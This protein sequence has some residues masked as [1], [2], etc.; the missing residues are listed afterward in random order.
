ML[1]P[2]WD[3]SLQHPKIGKNIMAWG[4]WDDYIASIMIFRKCPF[5]KQK[6]KFCMVNSHFG[7]INRP[8]EFPLFLLQGRYCVRWWS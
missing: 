8:L 5:V 7:I 1:N 2:S 4:H 3:A 6:Q